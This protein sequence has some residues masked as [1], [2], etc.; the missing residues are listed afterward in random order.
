MRILYVITKSEMGGAQ[1]VVLTYLRHLANIAEV[2][3]A[4]G[5]E[6]FLA[7]EARS[8]GIPVF[9]LP[10]MVMPIA[11]RRD[12][13]ALQSLHKLIRAYEPDLVHAHSSKAGLLARLAARLAGVSSVFTAHGFAFTENASFRRR[14]IA[15]PSEWLAARIGQSV[16]AVSRYDGAL[17][18]RYGVL[19][20][21]QVNVIHNGLPDV[22][23]R[24]RPAE[25]AQVNIVMVARFAPPK[26]HESVLQAMTGLQGH[27][28]LWLVGDGPTVSRVR[29]E[30]FRLG[31]D[32]HVV[33]LGARND[34]PELLAKAHIF[35]LASDYEGLP[36]SILEA[37]R[38]GLPV[39]ASDVGGVNECVT[40]GSTGFLV[41]RGD[42]E[43]I[44]TRLQRLIASPGLRNQMGRAGRKS[45]EDQFSA[46]VMVHKTL[47]VYET[48]LG[49]V[50][51]HMDG[52]DRHE[53]T[54]S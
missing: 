11:P 28:R 6:G 38:A 53:V 34:V 43:L 36:I 46:D 40:E 13:R 31:V 35:V 22:D 19:S 30:A 2:A 33:F 14:S 25:G 1:M 21:S 54:A 23:F 27:F 16:I 39:V 50:S 10:D 15:I 44:Q 51:K 26:A 47:A 20:R 42:P 12:C 24:A 52:S 29:S 32:D 41:K 4:T 18:T 8:L 17:A 9:V 3:L 7:G 45:F 49:L 37:M 5:D 48:A